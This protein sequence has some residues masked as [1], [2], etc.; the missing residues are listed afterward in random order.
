MASGQF[1]GG[2]HNLLGSFIRSVEIGSDD[3][4][5]FTGDLLDCSFDLLP[6][7]LLDVLNGRFGTADKSLVSVSL[8]LEAFNCRNHCLTVP[9]RFED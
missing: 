4:G 3:L 7:P 8:G 6:G 9:L 1:G 5:S 2:C